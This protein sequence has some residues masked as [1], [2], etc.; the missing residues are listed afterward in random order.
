MGVCWWLNGLR[1]QHCHH[2]HVVQSDL[3]TSVWQG[4]RQKKKRKECTYITESLCY[5][6]EINTV[7]QL[8]FNKL[9]KVRGKRKNETANIATEIT[10]SLVKM[11]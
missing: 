2:Y 3:G 1:I 6:A 9:K 7:N 8:Y 11:I 10:T 4:H 5:T